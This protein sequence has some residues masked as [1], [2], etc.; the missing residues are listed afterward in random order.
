LNR[1]KNGF[2][3]IRF[4]LCGVFFAFMI[5]MTDPAAALLRLAYT[6]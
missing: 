1:Q 6:A 3:R 4:K 2:L 5:D